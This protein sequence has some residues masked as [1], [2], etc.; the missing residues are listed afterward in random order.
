MRYKDIA[1][2]DNAVKSG[3]DQTMT[4]SSLS[5][6]VSHVDNH[7][8]GFIT[9]YRGDRPHIENQ[10]ANMLL[11]ARLRENGFGVTAVFGSYIE[12]FGSDIANEVKEH[13]FFVHNPQDGD[14]N[15][16]L[17][18]FLCEQGQDFDQDSILS[19]PFDQDAYLIGTSPRETAYPPFG[20]R[21]RVGS[22]RAG[23][24]GEFMSR[25]N[26][27][28]FVFREYE[29]YEKPQTINGIRGQKLLAEKSVAD[30][31]IGERDP[32]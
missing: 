5:R 1:S 8:C 21:E 31:V 9:A 25:V 17:E 11:A 15:L 16:V 27:R 4:E 29:G 18:A 2:I 30:Y 28:P 3:I 7:A 14:D 13:S 32:K 23:E 26:K 24:V 22:I 10:R 12:N 20:E 6:I 19:I